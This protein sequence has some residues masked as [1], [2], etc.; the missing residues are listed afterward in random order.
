MKKLLSGALA[1]ILCVSMVA[2][3]VDQV[4]ADIEVVVQIAAS[5]VPAVGA[6]SPTDASVVQKLSDD[7]TAAIKVI[8]ADYDTY[9]ASGATSDLTRL[10]SAINAIQTSLPQELAAAH[11]S[12]PKT[13][14]KVTNWCNLIYSTVNAIVAAIPALTPVPVAAVSAKSV[15]APA[16]FPTAKVIVARW[17][18]EVCQ[19]DAACA[20]LVKVKKHFLGL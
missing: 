2:C 14:A 3:T 5:I 4:L 8:Q 17:N 15:S 1:L 18:S 10:Q 11:I 19:G 13:V 16:V 20:K 9:K 6:I 7:A 12:D